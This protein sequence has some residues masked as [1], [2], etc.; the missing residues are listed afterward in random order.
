[1]QQRLSELLSYMDSTRANLL[2]TIRGINPAFA[3]VRPRGDSWS[4][5]EIV[6]HLAIVEERISRLISDAVAWATANNVGPAT[7]GESVMSTLDEYSV[8]D[9][10]EKKQASTAVTPPEGRPLDESVKS[11]EVSRTRLRDALVTGDAFDMGKVKRP[12]ASF[13]D[14]DVFQWALFVAQHEERHRKQIERTMDEVT[15]LAAE[16]APIV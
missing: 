10:A 6:A 4:V 5:E 15:E 2:G 16:C 12:H 1:M 3:G 9:S 8:V 13:G 11:L 14:L 7:G